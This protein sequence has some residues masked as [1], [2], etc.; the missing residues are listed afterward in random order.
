[1]YMTDILQIGTLLGILGIIGTGVV[2]IWQTKYELQ[3]ISRENERMKIQLQ[4]QPGCVESRDITSDRKLIRW[5]VDAKQVNEVRAL[6]T[7]SLGVIHQ[8]R[9]DIKELLDKGRKIKFLLLDPR[10]DEFTQRIREVECRY[11][12]TTEDFHSHLSRL[13]AE[14]N[15]IFAIL[16]NISQNSNHSVLLEIRVRKERPTHSFTAVI[17][18]SQQECFA[19]IN[20]Y[21]LEG[22]GPRGKQFLCR[23]YE[24]AESLTFDT[25]MK[26]YDESWNNATPVSLT[27]DSWIL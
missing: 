7:N 4:G 19:F 24:A 15:A 8:A 3:N 5:A 22:R 6:G 12:G 9:E 26:I 16:R 18:P 14:W 10:S 2:Y 13:I 17:S 11:K 25:Y 23:K 20:L 21:P 27:D 1:M